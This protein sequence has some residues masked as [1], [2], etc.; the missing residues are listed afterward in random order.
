MRGKVRVSEEVSVLVCWDVGTEERGEKEDQESCGQFLVTISLRSL[1]I[2]GEN[3][4]HSTD[5]PMVDHLLVFS[6]LMTNSPYRLT[7]GSKI[8]SFHVYADPRDAN[9]ECPPK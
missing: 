2:G 3:E 1:F 7:L 4:V 6:S 9:D 8:P 5:H